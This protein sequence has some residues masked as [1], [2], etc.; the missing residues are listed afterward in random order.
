MI[1]VGQACTQLL[2]RMHK[3]AKRSSG[4]APGGRSNVS[5]LRY[6]AAPRRRAPRA[7]NAPAPPAKKTRRAAL[8][9]CEDAPAVSRV[10]S[11]FRI[12][13]SMS[14]NPLRGQ[15]RTHQSMPKIK[16]PPTKTP[17]PRQTR[18]M[19]KGFVALFNAKGLLKM[20]SGSI[21]SSTGYPTTEPTNVRIATYLPMGGHL[22]QKLALR[23]PRWLV[24]SRRKPVG[25]RYRQN[26]RF[27]NELA[28]ATTS[29][30]SAPTPMDRV[31]MLDERATNGL[32]CCNNRGAIVQGTSGQTSTT[33]PTK[34]V[35]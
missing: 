35:S 25:Q 23:N 26:H 2:Q 19:E 8:K 9:R 6:R 21:H 33:A 7:S 5:L 12:A 11:A 27:L 4:T 3:P 29:A 22:L 24:F 32:V 28:M 31:A 17:R 15:M 1:F 14:C 13:N 20:Q 10:Q 34:Q 30:R 18:I 16:V